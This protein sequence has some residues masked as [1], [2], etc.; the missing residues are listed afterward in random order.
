MGKQP[1]Q[2][3][4]TGLEIPRDRDLCDVAEE[5][6]ADTPEM[7][8]QAVHLPQRALDFRRGAGQAA[9]APAHWG[10]PG[11]AR[12]GCSSSS[13]VGGG[14]GDGVMSQNLP[15]PSSWTSCQ[16]CFMLRASCCQAL[17]AAFSPLRLWFAQTVSNY[18]FDWKSTCLPPP[19]LWT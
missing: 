10:A 18:L 19:G 9:G 17:V 16:G 1:L 12:Q 15:E 8:G 13:I 6:R 14:V 5:L 4:N 11:G 7:R 2:K 3:R